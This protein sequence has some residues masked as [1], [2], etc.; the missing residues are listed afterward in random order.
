MNQASPLC[1]HGRLAGRGP[2]DKTCMAYTATLRRATSRP[3]GQ[4]ALMSPAAAQ[5]ARWASVNVTMLTHNKNFE[6]SHQPCSGERGHGAGRGAW[7]SNKI[8]HLGI[9]CAA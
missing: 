4:P 7:R 6:G 8:E 5:R 2:V 1:R 3:E 9:R